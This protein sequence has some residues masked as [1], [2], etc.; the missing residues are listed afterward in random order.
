MQN[1]LNLLDENW[2]YLAVFMCG[3]LFAI[4]SLGPVRAITIT[5]SLHSIMV[6]RI[7]FVI[8]SHKSECSTDALFYSLLNE[9]LMSVR[10][11]RNIN[12]DHVFSV[13]HN[14]SLDKDCEEEI[15]SYIKDVAAILNMINKRRFLYVFNIERVLRKI[16]KEY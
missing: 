2:K 15:I 12:L 11:R 4:V 16:E 6:T 10:Y 8:R 14:L 1:I 3:Y 7:I 13:L 9:Q 5:C